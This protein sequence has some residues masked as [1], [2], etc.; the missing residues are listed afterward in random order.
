MP[1]CEWMLNAAQLTTAW[2]TCTEGTHVVY[3]YGRVPSSW[4]PIRGLN[5]IRGAGIG[6][7]SLSA[8]ASSTCGKPCWGYAQ[9]WNG[10]L[11][12]NSRQCFQSE[13]TPDSTQPHALGRRDDGHPALQ[14][15]MR[16]MVCHRVGSEW[17][18][19]QYSM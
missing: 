19:T 16:H 17:V 5:F 12:W 3:M 11:N 4:Q 15:R 8:L 6:H 13:N 10:E 1:M 7:S 14:P 2:N 18:D 9:Q